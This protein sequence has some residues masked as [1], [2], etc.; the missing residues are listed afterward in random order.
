MN[1]VSHHS[2]AQ[3]QKRY[4][5]EKDARLARR[6]QG[7]YLA[8]SGKN[9]PQ[10]MAITGAA[11]RT[12]QQWVAKYNRGGLDE[13]C[14]KP[15]PGQPTRLPRDREEEFRRRLD[16]GPLPSDGVSVL[17]APVI[18]RILEREFGQTYSLPGVWGL[19]HRLGY[20]YLCP[21]PQ[22]ERADPIA[23]ETFKKT[24][25]PCWIRSKTSTPDEGSKSGSRTKPG[26]ASKE[27]SR[28]SGRKKAVDR[29]PFD[30]PDIIRNMIN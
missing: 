12:V 3:L 15:R 16:Q 30:K 20:A 22:H 24:S 8:L 18:Q 1:V 11:R 21:R 9:C 10:I 14:D 27:R 5:M 26:L 4:R 17:T 29:E 25:P 6:I 13:L 23:Q 2:P 7:V 28:G 19:L